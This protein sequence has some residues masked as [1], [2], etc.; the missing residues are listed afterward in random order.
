MLDKISHDYIDMNE[1]RVVSYQHSINQPQISL[2][3]GRPTQVA[4]CGVFELT[5]RKGKLS[6]CVGLFFPQD[7]SRVLYQTEF[8]EGN[9][10]QEALEKV[11]GLISQM[12]FLMTDSNFTSL[13]SQAQQQLIRLSPFVYRD[14]SSY[15]QALSRSEVRFKQNQSEISVKRDVAA[16]RQQQFIEQYVT[17]LSML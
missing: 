14:I 9:L 3:D 10:R 15:F 1:F 17:I 7:N 5:T 8:E 13:D 6:F 16:I 2:G 4:S 12:G 11:E